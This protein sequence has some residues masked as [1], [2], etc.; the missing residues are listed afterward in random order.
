MTIKELF[1]AI[2]EKTSA[3]EDTVLATI[4]AEIG[5][6]PR[7]A[8]AHMLVGKNGR[9]CGTIGGGTLEY[10]SIQLAQKFLEHQISRRKIYRLYANDEEDLGMLCGG[11][12]EIFFQCIAGKDE[13]NIS[14][15]QEILAT[16]DM[17][18]DS[19]LFTDLTDPSDWSMRLYRAH[20]PP[21]G[22]D[23]SGHDLMALT[24]NKGVLV[25]TAGRCIYSEPINFAGK[26]FIFGAGHVA[27]ALE[28]V[29]TTVGFRCVIFDNREEFVSRELFPTA[30]DVICGDYAG[31]RHQ[32]TIRSHDY[33]VIVTHAYDL[34]VLRQLIA[35]D[36]VYIGVIGSQG[37]IAAV[38]QQLHAEGVGEARLNKLNA[39]IGIKIRSETPEEIAISIAGEMILRRAE[40]RQA[41]RSS[42]T[43][44]IPENRTGFP[45]DHGV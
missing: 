32:I 42:A 28:P 37:K 1:T 9:I 30:Y 31:I 38:K 5:S 26:V 29:L 33:I 44:G 16:L 39:P 45:A 14:L 6:S 17:D 34:A 35:V 19:W 20:N 25:K 41:T 40:S 23:L 8:G 27:Q 2:L 22:I 12:V 7:S 36:C 4:V 3:G 21:Q 24:R 11:D 10:Q 43:L 15:I 13:K 18:E